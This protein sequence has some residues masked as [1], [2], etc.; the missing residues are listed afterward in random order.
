L[1]AKQENHMNTRFVTWTIVAICLTG[2]AGCG[3]ES[4][5]IPSAPTSSTPPPGPTSPPPPP[6][7]STAL[8]LTGNYALTFEVGNGCELVPK[9]LRIRTYEARIRYHN[10]YESSDNFLA[11]LSGAT[12]VNQQPVR[13]EVT[14]QASGATVWLDLA[15]S[16]N[17]ILEE[18]ERGAYFIAAG[19]EG[20][21]S[22][23]SPQL[24]T[25]S[26]SLTGYFNYCVGAQNQCSFDAMVRSMCV[27]ENSRWTLTRR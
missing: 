2:V 13:I 5:S 22:V 19:W 14:Q 10:S 11:E 20:M 12:F 15:P 9:E 25:I 24:S 18:L 1:I 23:Q 16:D 6:P 27:S 21:A 4:P 8:D 3:S 17:V 7:R 26:A